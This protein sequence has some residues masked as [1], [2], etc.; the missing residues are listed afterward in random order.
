MNG[1]PSFGPVAPHYDVLMEHVPYEMWVSYYRLLL[2]Q[3]GA[4]PQRLLDVCCGTGTVG[5]LLA[6]EGMH[7]TGIDLSEPMIEIARARA[8]AN[9][10]RLEFHV[11]DATAFDLGKQFEG[12]YSFFDSLNYITSLE[13][14]RAALGQ[15][16]R[17]LEPGSTFVFDLNTAYAFEQRMFD[18]KE[19]DKNAPIR[20]RWK[21]DYDAGTRLIRVDMAFERHG[22]EFFETHWQ[23]AH[24][25]EEVTEGLAD[26]G[27]ERVEIFE[28]Y[29]LNPPR[30]TSDR[31][32]VVARLAGPR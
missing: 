15:V 29:T 11:A 32:H 22:H 31:V 30:K 26:A 12:A 9:P 24:T 18:Q 1:H 27:F 3:S 2:A 7:V 13:G 20:Y 10:E 4:A 28:S 23:R 19:R 5:E 16:R 21:G 17:H 14:L 8:A 6:K 25:L